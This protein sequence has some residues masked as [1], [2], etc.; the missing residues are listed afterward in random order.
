MEELLYGW[1]KLH[2]KEPLTPDRLQKFTQEFMNTALLAEGARRKK[3]NASQGHTLDM[4][5]FEK[6]V[7][8]RDMLASVN[9]KTDKDAVKT[10]YETHTKDF[11]KPD[12]VQLQHILLRS[13]DDAEA[14]GARLAKGDAFDA[15]AR[16]VSADRDNLT[17]GTEIGWVMVSDD[18][19][20]HVGM[21]PAFAGRMLKHD[22]GYTTGPIQTARGF[23]WFRLAG[24]RENEPEPFDTIEDQ[25]EK[26]WKREANEAAQKSLLEDLKKEIPV[27]LHDDVLKQAIKSSK[28]AKSKD[29]K[30]SAVLPSA[31]SNSAAPDPA[32]AESTQAAQ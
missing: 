22:Q 9:P 10:Y 3:L 25:V 8:S 18:F 15:V 6:Q 17:S 7:L 11:L 13:K 28:G 4:R 31:D 19:I 20:P 12:A 1:N 16:G 2:G 21:M 24:K 29:D 27:T 23:H 26:K 32:G 14:V 5:L 30:T